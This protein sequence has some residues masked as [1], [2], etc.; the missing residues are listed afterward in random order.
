MA[1]PA[2]VS[3]S[4][5]SSPVEGTHPLNA[6]DSIAQ[7]AE[8]VKNGGSRD[9]LS[10]VLFGKKQADLNTMTEAQQD[11]VFRANEEGTVGMDAAGKVFQI[12]PEQHTD[13]RRM[14][15]IGGRDVNA[16]Q[17]DHPELHRY[18]QEAAQALI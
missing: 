11:A 13:R 1:G 12:D 7:E 18:Y 9:I 14:E 4:A 16:F 6:D 10:E 5:A 17:F 15:T 2:P 8:N 3:S